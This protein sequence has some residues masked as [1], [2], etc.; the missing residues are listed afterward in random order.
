MDDTKNWL[1][2]VFKMD[3]EEKM[4]YICTKDGEIID[5]LSSREKYAKLEDGDRVLQAGEGKRA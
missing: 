3:I 4:L 5:T 1:E 2:L